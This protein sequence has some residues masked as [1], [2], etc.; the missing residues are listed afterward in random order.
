MSAPSV[1]VC[2]A[3]GRTGGAVVDHLLDAHRDGELRLIAAVRRP[4]AA[5][6]FEERGIEVRHL[7]LDAA[8]RHGLEPLVAGLRDVRRVFLA[9]GYDV[10]MLG[11]AK[12]AVDA[13]RSAG[14]E[15]VVHLGVHA[16]PDTTVVH[17][18]WHRLVE[19]YLARSGVGHTNLHPTS[20]MQNLLMPVMS[21]PGSAVL[22]H[23]IGDAATS[24]VDTEDIAAV[25]AAV[26]RSPYEH[27]ERD[28]GL[29]AEVAT[30]GGIAAVLSELTGRPWRY[31]PRDPAEFFTTMTEAGADPLYMDCVRNVFERTREGSLPELADT[32]DTVERI[33]GRP[34]TTLRD[35]LDRHR[36]H[37]EPTGP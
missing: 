22:T 9:S 35:F 29:G 31:D 5:A 4:E 15:H 33:A 2:G 12:A 26:L 32:F 21:D 6:D 1:L 36:A 17:F 27:E 25:A 18:A 8:E 19:A 37:F 24:W 28:Y 10:R 23:Y 16:A 3:T 7:D 13:A 20:F 14:V 30:I 34:A 11:Q